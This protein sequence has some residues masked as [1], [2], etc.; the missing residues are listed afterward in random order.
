M[1]HKENNIDVPIKSIEIKNMATFNLEG[2]K[3]ENL[4]KVNLMNYNSLEP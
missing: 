3:L 4:S 2:A 1:G